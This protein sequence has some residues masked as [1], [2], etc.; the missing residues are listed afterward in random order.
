MPAADP[1]DAAKAPSM[2]DRM[3]ALMAKCF[4]GMGKKFESM[5]GDALKKHGE[6]DGDEKSEAEKPDD[7]KKDE[8]P[9]AEAAQ[10]TTPAAGP[11]AHL[12]PAVSQAK[13]GESFAVL[14]DR[15][16][17]M[18]KEN[19]L[20][21]GELGKARREREAESFAVAAEAQLVAAGVAVTA[22]MRADLRADAF[23]SKQAVD[24]TVTREIR[25]H[26]ARPA[27]GSPDLYGAALGGAVSG[28]AGVHPDKAKALET[29]GATREGQIRVEELFASWAMD[30]AAQ[31]FS[32]ASICRGD[33]VLNPAI[34]GPRGGFPSRPA[35]EGS[36]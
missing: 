15:I 9:K 12:P 24:R 22:D 18:E 35:L 34:N 23:E 30:R 2:E 13:P 36:R 4:E 6:P 29:Y 14:T 26:K 11:N 31:K 20:L 8:K 7:E 17:R 1:K 27:G 33:E 10:A 21:K 19:L 25:N 32:F 5:I 3:E 16:D 28:F